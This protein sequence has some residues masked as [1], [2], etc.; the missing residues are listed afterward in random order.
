MDINNHSYGKEDDLPEGA[1]GDKEKMISIVRAS[2]NE[3]LSIAEKAGLWERI[4]ADITQPPVRLWWRSW[5]VAAA[6]ALLLT[7]GMGWWQWQRTQEA[8]PALVA[9][10]SGQTYTRGDSTVTRMILGNQQQLNIR[11]T[12][13]AITYQAKGTQLRID[14]QEIRQ[15]LAAGRPVFNT[16]LVPYGNVASLQLEDGTRV[17]L[18]AGSRLVYPAAFAA[19]RREVFLE[20][21]AYFD[22]AADADRPFSVYA[23]DM[24]IAV[25]G[26]AFNISAYREDAASQVVLAS[27]SVQLEAFRGPGKAAAPVQLSPGNRASYAGRD[28]QMTVD[29]VNV[30]GHISW[31]DGIIVAEHTSLH[32]ILRKLSR[33]YNQPIT[34]DAR[35]GNET[36]SGNLDL[37]KTLNDVLDIIAASTSL[38]YEKQGGTIIFKTR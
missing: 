11:N 17:W 9:F 21:E 4:A 32:E 22:V 27:G 23:N 15:E 7:A 18:N 19:G 14:S 28:G 2:G 1:G 33:Y 6:V 5:K 31:K 30:A 25:L 20:G 35:S 37:Q 24:K 10:A 29:N 36:F 16:L 38:K 26:T 13:A 34:T 8:L 3:Q 12:H